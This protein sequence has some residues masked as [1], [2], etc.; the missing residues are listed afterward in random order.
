M[1]IDVW[2]DIACPWSYLGIRHLRQALREFP[3]RDEV[4]V[5]LHAYFLDPELSE[6]LDISRA[7]YLLQTEGMTAQKVIDHEERLRSLGRSEGVDFDFARVVVAPTANAHRTVSLA[8]EID[9]EADTVMGPETTQLRMFETLGRAYFEM[10]LNVADP[11]V[12]IGCGQDIGM[13]P[14]RILEA[15]SSREWASQVFSDYQIGVQMGIDLIPTYLFDR[16]FVVQDHQPVTAMRNILAT[17][18]EQSS[19]EH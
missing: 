1:H 9:L 5:L 10:G 4:E 14:R 12:L 18:W 11:E 13:D 7:D 19:K 3:Q 6:P 17:A 15:L 8:H 2:A 16:A